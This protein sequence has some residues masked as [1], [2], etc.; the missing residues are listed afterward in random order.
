MNCKVCGE[1]FVEWEGSPENCRQ[2]LDDT[3][4]RPCRFC[5]KYVVVY[6][7]YG[8]IETEYVSSANF[9]LTF[10]PPYKVAWITKLNDLDNKLWKEI[11]EVKI[12]ELTPELAVKWA[13]KLKTYSVFQ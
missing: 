1:P 5:H 4:S 6:D 11:D 7:A 3:V 9:I 13:N 8:N 10:L 2:I 12:D